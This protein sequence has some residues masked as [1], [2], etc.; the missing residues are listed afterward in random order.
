M[1]NNEIKNQKSKNKQLC[2]YFMRNIMIS[3]FINIHTIINTVTN[4]I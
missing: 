3:I 1:R 2:Y 4:T